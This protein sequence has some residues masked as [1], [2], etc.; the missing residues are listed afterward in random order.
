ME[1]IME[2][3]KKKKFPVAVIFL[4]LYALCLF[5]GCIGP[6]IYNHVYNEKLTFY[7]YSV[8]FSL[9][10][11]LVILSVFLL[12]KKS[13]KPIAFLVITLLTLQVCVLLD[14]LDFFVDIIKL[15]NRYNLEAPNGVIPFYFIELL[16]EFFIVSL[17]GIILYNALLET[18]IA[19]C[20]KNNAK[21]VVNKIFKFIAISCILINVVQSII[22]FFKE[23][24]IFGFANYNYWTSSAKF[25]FCQIFDN[26]L[27]VIGVML[28]NAY[29]LNPYVDEKKK[30]SYNYSS[31]EKV[32]GAAK[33]S[34]LYYQ[35]MGKHVL[36]LLLTG[37]IWWYIWI[38]KTTEFTNSS[39]KEYRNPVN[40]LL[41]CLFVP[42]YII[43]WTYKT[44]LLID[45]ISYDNGIYSD[46]STVCLILAIFVPWITPIIMQDKINA[47][48]AK[49]NK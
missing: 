6:D 37:G 10:L 16:I 9:I 36:L 43:Y 42:F 24:Y 17:A 39:K 13:L 38:Y 47:V 34:Y 33:L 23:D 8:D 27:F 28:L 14:A 48:I 49:N 3:Q 26:I 21:V 29:I 32:E 44:A 46:S 11:I 20:K 7:I 40:K 30:E 15:L 4:L 2:Q 22:Y 25:I 45:S 18:K 19:E 31:A 41:L 12:K 35:S 1:Q 5:I